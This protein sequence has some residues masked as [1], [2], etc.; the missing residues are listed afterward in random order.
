MEDDDEEVTAATLRGKPRPVPISALSA[1]SYV[2]PR[3]QDPKEHSYYYRQ[4]RVSG[5]GVRLRG[6]AAAE[7]GTEAGRWGPRTG[8]HCREGAGGAGNGMG[9]SFT[10]GGAGEEMGAGCTDGEGGGGGQEE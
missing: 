8:P 1:F 5:P 9:R 4:G 10:A 6:G 3:R 2:P 7:P